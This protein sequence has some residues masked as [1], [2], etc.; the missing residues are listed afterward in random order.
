MENH[1]VQV[2]TAL[3]ETQNALQNEWNSLNTRR[4]AKD[5]QSNLARLELTRC[6]KKLAKYRERLSTLIQADDEILGTRV[7]AEEY[8]WIIN[9]LL[10]QEVNVAGRRVD[11]IAECP[12]AYVKKT[13]NGGSQW[14]DEVLQ[15]STWSA[16]IT[17]SALRDLGGTA[18]IYAKSKDKN[19]AEVRELEE[20]I[21]DQE[22]HLE[23]LNDSI[24]DGDGDGDDE[25]ITELTSKIG[26]V[27]DLVEKLKGEKVDIKMYQDLRRFYARQGRASTDEIRE[28]INFYDSD[29]AKLVGKH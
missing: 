27:G 22:E 13:T 18:T 19:R 5:Q 17:S 11:F 3:L 16:V 8:S 6:K 12:I 1:D 25:K 10:K 21:T 23:H 14:Q 26:R 2:V 20:K 4:S 29:V 28:F 7:A 9:L 24:K 15:G